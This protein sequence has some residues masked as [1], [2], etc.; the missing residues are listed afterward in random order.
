MDHI[1]LDTEI[2]YSPDEVLRGFEATDIL[3]L[4][5]A[6]LYEVKQMRMRIYGQEDIDTLRARLLRADRITTFNGERF[7]FPLIFGAS[8]AAWRSHEY[9]TVRTP[10]ESKSNDL[11][12]RIWRSRGLD[13]DKFDKRTHGGWGLGVVCLDTIGRGKIGNGALAPRDFQAGLWAKVVNYCCDDVMLTY[14]LSEFIDRYGYV[15]RDM[16]QYLII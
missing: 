12:A 5:V 14:E 15:V 3:G 11:L 4:S 7:D 8:Q 1:V 13:P 6:C 2:R 10:L 16:R 9:D